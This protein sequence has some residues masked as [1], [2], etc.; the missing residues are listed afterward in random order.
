[1]PR[2]AAWAAILVVAAL[3]GLALQAAGVLAAWFLGPC[4]VGIAAGS[5]GLFAGRVPR[6]VTVWCQAAIGTLI[7]STIVPGTIAAVAA[8]APALIAAVAATLL[9]ATAAGVVLARTTSLGAATAGWGITPGGAI[10]MTAMSENFGADSRLVAFM[11]Y[12]RLLVVVFTVSLVAHLMGADR[13]G[14]TPLSGAALPSFDWRD[15]AETLAVAIGSTA[16]FLRLGVRSAGLFGPLAFGGTLHALGIVHLTLPPVLLHAAY[17]LVGIGIG[18]RFTRETVAHALRAM[19]AVFAA[20]LAVIALCAG[21]GY[22]LHRATGIDMLTAY[23]ATSPGGLDSIALVAVG[24][25]AD[26]GLVL[27]LQSLRLVAVVL[28]GPMI[29]QRITASAGGPPGRA[30][31]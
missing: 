8:H 7:A 1:M 16:L 9:A 21:S 5:T 13:G 11:Q 19:P 6:P 17:A 2:A 30:T 25:H 22:L 14:P 10:A 18:L 28:L 4:V 20:T 15:F 27:A 12:T 3:A 24:S 29:A 26:M 23:L 31:G